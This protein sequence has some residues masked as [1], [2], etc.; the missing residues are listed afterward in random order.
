M[1]AANSTAAN[2][3]AHGF[4]DGFR[5]GTATAAH[6]IEGGNTNNDW[7]RWEHRPDTPCAESSGDA[8]DSWHRWREDVELVAGL[9]LDHYRFSVEWSRIE[10]APGEWSRAALDHY[11]RQ[12]AALRE[13][14][15]DPI[16]TF[17]HFTTPAWLADRGGWEDP[18][19]VEL[20]GRFCETTAQALAGVMSRACTLNEPNVVATMGWVMGLFPPGRSRPEEARRVSDHLIAAHRRAVDAIRANAPGVPVGLTLSMTDYQPAPGRDGAPE[21][22]A[23]IHETHEDVFLR[24]TA[25]DDFLGVQTYSRM[26][27]GPDGW[28]G[29]APGVEVLPMGYEY[30]PAALE[31]C[32]RRAWAVTGGAVPLWV[33][34]N[35]IGTEDDQQR[36]R[37]VREALAGLLAAMHDGVQVGGYTYWSL[38]D[39][40]EW[41]FGFKPKFGLV[42]VDRPT[43]ARRPKPSAE[44]LAGVARANSLP[45][46]PG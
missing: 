40:F 7:W 33:T 35:G 46:L 17:H 15:I 8:C 39:N 25:G 22:V 3:T 10:P 42:S 26:L 28:V 9:G 24:A 20:F 1:P 23:K 30:W 11:R 44:W 4:P 12:A 5:W 34:E 14:G 18:A 27:I 6:Q 45:P 2:S 19:V 16:V 37:Y 21:R 32:V 38:L 31:A 29:P 41:A 43:F 36:I 13:R